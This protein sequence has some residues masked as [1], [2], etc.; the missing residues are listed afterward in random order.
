M[1]TNITK[2]QFFMI[3]D[4]ADYLCKIGSWNEEGG[5]YPEID[6]NLVLK[7]SDELDALAYHIYPD[8]EDK[9]NNPF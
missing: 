1:K 6:H 9:T 2:K 8:D 4:V 3:Q 7:Y 5:C